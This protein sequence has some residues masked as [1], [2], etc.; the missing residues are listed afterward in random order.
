MQ[1]EQLHCLGGRC[2]NIE[3]LQFHYE[4]LCMHLLEIGTAISRPVTSSITSLYFMTIVR[5]GCI[6]VWTQ[7]MLNAKARAIIR[8]LGDNMLMESSLYYTKADNAEHVTHS[9]KPDV[10]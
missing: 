10:T 4:F 8:K 3:L 7:C 1:C 5:L 2:N 9:T 6:N